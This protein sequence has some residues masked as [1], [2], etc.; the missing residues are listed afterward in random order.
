[1][2]LNSF[3]AQLEEYGQLMINWARPEGW[4]A[5]PAA[6]RIL[7]IAVV[8]IDCVVIMC[9]VDCVRTGLW[10]TLLLLAKL[11]LDTC[12]LCSLAE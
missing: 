3:D 8:L 7:Y 4:P 10:L 5:S 9:N 2:N 1:M 6:V 12:V 11:P